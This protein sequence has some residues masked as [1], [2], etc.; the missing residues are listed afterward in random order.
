VISAQNNTKIGEDIPV[1]DGP[2][3]I[4][5]SVILFTVYVAN[6]GSDNISVIDGASNKVVAGVTFHVDPFNSGRILCDGLTTP[7]Q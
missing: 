4:G 6:H 3:G 2:V 7:L 5:V 1:G